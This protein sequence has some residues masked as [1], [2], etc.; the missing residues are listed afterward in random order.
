MNCSK[1]ISKNIGVECVSN[2]KGYKSRGVI[3]NYDDIDFSALKRSA[4]NPHVIEELVLKE[5]KYGYVLMHRGTAF[6]GT[7]A[8]M[9]RG[10]YGN[11]N[12]NNVVFI[13]PHDADTV[14]K[15]TQPL[16]NDAEVV[17]IL[18]TKSKGADGKSAFEVFG[19]QGGLV[20]NANTYDANGEAGKNDIITLTEETESMGEFLWNSDYAATK[21]MVDGLTKGAYSQALSN[22][23]D[24]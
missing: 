10:T 6:N 11:T 7:N 5:G 4:D 24:N 16:M 3:I 1:I 20:A 18:E 23:F 14:H 22:D 13:A 17:V 8:A 9:S 21:L 2:A 12:I 19:L 15:V